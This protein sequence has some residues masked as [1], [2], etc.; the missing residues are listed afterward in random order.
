MG[1]TLRCYKEDLSYFY[2][3]VSVKYDD[4]ISQKVFESFL[5]QELDA[6]KKV[7]SL[8]SRIRGLRVFFNFCAEREYMK[9][10][11]VKLMKEGETIKE[12]YT[13]TVNCPILC[14]QYKKEPLVGK[15]EF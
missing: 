11:D 10:I 8:N 15:I 12:P 13:Y 14:G 3:K 9:P 4:E 2:S 1:Q 6:S 5:L 7:T